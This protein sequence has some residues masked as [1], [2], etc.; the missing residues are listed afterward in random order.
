MPE[1]ETIDVERIVADLRERV[2]RERA[3]GLWEDADELTRHALVVP[4]GHGLADGFDL[5]A[6]PRIRFRPELGFSAK[7]VVGRL[8]TGVKQFI[9]RLLFYVFDD[10][11]RQADAAVMR[12]EAAL[13]AEVAARERAE[14]AAADAVRAEKSAREAVELELDGLSKRLAAFEERT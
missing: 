14:Q 8:I 2:E 6:G 1:N 4:P 11:A 12:L 10:L 7:P 3:D 5:G 13:A 9:L